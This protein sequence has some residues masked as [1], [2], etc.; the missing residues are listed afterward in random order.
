[1]GLG[2]CIMK[3]SNNHSLHLVLILIML[4][5]SGVAVQIPST[6]NEAHMQEA[7]S[8]AVLPIKARVQSLVYT[9][10]VDSIVDGLSRYFVGSMHHALTAF[11]TMEQCP[12]SAAEKSA[13]LLGLVNKLRNHEA[14]QALICKHLVDVY[15]SLSHEPVLYAAVKSNHPE[16]V[17]DIVRWG[18]DYKYPQID[19]LMLQAFAYAVKND[20]LK[21][22]EKLYLHGAYLKQDQAS[23]LLKTVIC[24]NKK[25]EMARFFI[26]RTHA[27]INY[28]DDTN[29]PLLAYALAHNNKAFI[30][31]IKSS[32]KNA[33]GTIIAL[34]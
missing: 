31:A 20:D 29:K 16:T 6:K 18:V 25:I 3:R 32:K 14:D 2:V 21:A 12:L 28:V 34:R 26:E 10:N 9:G 19:T 4:L 1:V 5:V 17:K 7:S 22:I 15:M 23:Q 30:H 33:Q 8:Q 11:S 27:D 24:E 13:V